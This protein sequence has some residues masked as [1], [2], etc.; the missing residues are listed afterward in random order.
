LAR[1][2]GRTT[3]DGE[4]CFGCGVCVHHCAQGAVSLMRDERKGVPL[5]VCAL[6]REG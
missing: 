3:V 5:E 6:V 4:K 2:E 1:V